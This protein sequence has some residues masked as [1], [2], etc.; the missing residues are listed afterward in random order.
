MS[1]TPL[2]GYYSLRFSANTDLTIG[3][4]WYNWHALENLPACQVFQFPPASELRFRLSPVAEAGEFAII[5]IPLQAAL[6]TMLPQ[7]RYQLNPYRWHRVKQQLSQGEIEN[8]EMGYGYSGADLMDGR[9]R[10]VAMMRL[11]GMDRAPFAVHPDRA[12]AV[13]D[14]FARLA[15]QA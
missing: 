12:E 8:P 15:L 14:H 9:H 2:S 13:R 4:E 10:I 5:E 1:N 7:M 11:M 3:D 6:D